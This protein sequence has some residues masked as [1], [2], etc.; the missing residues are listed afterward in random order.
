MKS[1]FF[2]IKEDFVCDFSEVEN[3]TSCNEPSCERKASF[4]I[5]FKMLERGCDCNEK[6]KE[7]DWIQALKTIAPR[8][9]IEDR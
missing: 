3:A 4:D 8:W 9:N 2:S 6:I 5:V 7:E 1:L